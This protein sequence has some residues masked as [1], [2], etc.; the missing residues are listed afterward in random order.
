MAHICFLSGKFPA[1]ALSPQML[2]NIKRTSAVIY[3][4]YRTLGLIITSYMYK[5]I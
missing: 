5:I 2:R 3:R 1:W 4:R